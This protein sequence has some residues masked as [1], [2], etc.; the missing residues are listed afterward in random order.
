M[1]HILSEGIFSTGF[2]LRVFFSHNT[3][4][5]GMNKRVK[6]LI[7]ELELLNPNESVFSLYYTKEDVKQ[8]EYYQDNTYPYDDYLAESTIDSLHNDSQIKEIV[9]DY[10][11]DRLRDLTSVEVITRS[12]DVE[13]VEG[14]F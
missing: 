1:K 8:L 13:M 4:R 5:E 3:Q 2:F 6:D 7:S 14:S 10:V 9:S 11:M 12:K